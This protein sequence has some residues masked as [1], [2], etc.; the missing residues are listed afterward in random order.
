M[1]ATRSFERHAVV[2]REHLTY[3]SSQFGTE[4]WIQV[5]PGHFLQASLHSCSA[6]MKRGFDALS[7]SDT[8][9]QLDPSKSPSRKSTRASQ[10]CELCRL[11]KQKCDGQYPCSNCTRWNTTCSFKEVPPT[12]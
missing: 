12:K 9:Q 2:C 4:L 1:H 10:A 8:D 6:R 3:I 7:Y 5:Y 11:R